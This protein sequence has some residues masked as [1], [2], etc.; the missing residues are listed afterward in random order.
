MS[1]PVQQQ[2][3]E[4][5]AQAFVKIFVA[6]LQRSAAFYGQALGY[7]EVARFAVPEFDELILRPAEGARGG[8]LVLCR[9]KD[10]RALDLGNAHGPI[11][12]T[13]TDVDAAHARILAA[14]GVSKIAPLDVQSSRVAIVADLDGHALELLTLGKPAARG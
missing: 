10:G 12:F 6:E 3:A 5:A 7:A 8:S 11:G 14:G 9:W 1:A 4:G 2:A 13:V